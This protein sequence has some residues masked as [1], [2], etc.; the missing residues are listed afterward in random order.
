MKRSSGN[1]NLSSTK[2][3]FVI[4]IDG[5]AAS[6]KSTAAY[7]LAK[8]LGF[9]YLDTGAMYRALTWKV[10]EQ[11]VNPEDESSI[12]QVASTLDIRLAA[13]RDHPGTRVWVDGK[14]ISSLIR[15][16]QVNRWVSQVSSIPG[17][18]KALVEKQREIARKTS[19]VAEGRD[20][21]TVVFPEADV[22]I[23]LVASLEERARRR[24][25][26]LQEK[27]ISCDL[28]KVKDELYLRDKMDSERETSPLKK[29]PDAHLLDNTRLDISS[30]LNE[31]LKIVKSR[32]QVDQDQG[33]PLVV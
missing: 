14:E 1:Y 21:G 30:T 11:G 8:K 5:P 10:L 16:P 23:F 29:A 28:K 19:V 32:I 25:K 2:R 4:A 26:E 31:L 3:Y 6:G 17:V 9:T 27:G 12:S 20:M 13:C 33:D 24:W 7:L 15:T 22:K 18:R